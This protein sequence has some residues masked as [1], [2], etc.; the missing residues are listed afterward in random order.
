MAN[1]QAR[2]VGAAIGALAIAAPEALAFGRAALTSLLGWGLSNPD[3]VQNAAA[4]IAAAM[5]PPGVTLAPMSQLRKHEA[6]AGEYFAKKIGA[7]LLEQTG[8]AQ[9]DFLATSG[10]YSGKTF[11]FMLTS[12]GMGKVYGRDWKNVFGQVSD[13]L[14]KHDY[15]VLDYRNLTRT[16]RT[17]LD[18]FISGLGD[19]DGSRV[20]IL[21]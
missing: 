17:E 20:F 6:E 1:Q 16:Q 12:P 3:K 13:H 5:G 9:A 2:G 19:A 11:D 15:V 21:R 18:T 10:K 8:T 7:N 14:K 4:A